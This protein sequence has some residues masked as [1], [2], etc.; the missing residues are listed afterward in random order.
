MADPVLAAIFSRRSVGRV[1][2]PPHHTLEL[3]GRV[4]GHEPH[5][6]AE[7]G[8]PT[9]DEADR[10]HDHRVGTLDLGGL[11]GSEDPRPDSWVRDGLEIP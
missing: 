2:P 5:L 3:H 10:L 9:L 1:G 8:E 11:H 7:R 4:A 6:V